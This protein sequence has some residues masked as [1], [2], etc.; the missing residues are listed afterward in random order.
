L[1]QSGSSAF[2]SKKKTRSAI[3][4]PSSFQASAIRFVAFENF[5]RLL[6]IGNATTLTTERKLLAG[7]AA[8]C[9]GVLLTYPLDLIRTR[10]SLQVHERHY[11]G[12]FDAFRK[13]LAADGVRGLFRGVGAAFTSVAPFSALNFTFYEMLKEYVGP[14]IASKSI[15]LSA[16]YG[17]AS[18]TAAMTFLYPLDLL[19]RQ[20]MVQGHGDTPV[21]YKNG[22]HA[23]RVIVAE[24]GVGGLYRGIIPSYLKVIPTVSLTWL[25]YEVMKRWLG[26][27][28]KEGGTVSIG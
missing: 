16:G 5:K 7:S 21:R 3:T 11:D 6:L 25:S 13:I 20:L 10:L 18:G 2:F 15:L 1:H 24:Q 26:L 19:K 27:A 8:G 12:M 22:W 9:T 17:A 14:L 28:G 4:L 23:A